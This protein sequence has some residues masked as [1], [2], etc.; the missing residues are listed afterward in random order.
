MVK[1][2][3]IIRKLK[4]FYDYLNDLGEVLPFVLF[5][6]LPYLYDKI[7]GFSVVICFTISIVFIIPTSDF[8]FNVH[9]ID[10]G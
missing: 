8:Y 7:N 9:H 1:K 2:T 10:I 4:S 5:V 6:I 3:S